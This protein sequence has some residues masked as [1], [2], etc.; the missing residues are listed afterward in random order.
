MESHV[1][2]FL[3]NATVPQL[4]EKLD[5]MG[6][7]S[8]GLKAA[9]KLR[10][11]EAMASLSAGE[12]NAYFPANQVTL[13][14]NSIIST[15]IEV[16]ADLDKQIEVLRMQLKKK[17]E[18]LQLQ[19]KLSELV[20]EENEKTCASG[21]NF[22]DIEESMN[23]F[24]GDNNYCISKWITNFEELCEMFNLDNRSKFICAKRLMTGT[25]KLFLKTK[26]IKS[27]I[28]L[29]CELL[30]E[31]S[32]RVTNADVHWE[33]KNRKKTKEE[34]CQ[35]YVLKMQETASLGEIDEADLIQYIVDGIADT[36]V[37]KIL[38]YNAN[39]IEDL[40]NS[41]TKYEKLKLN[42][43]ISEAVKFGNK[44]KFSGRPSV[45]CFNCNEVGHTANLCQK[46][47]RP[48]GSCFVCGE[49]GHRANQ[50]PKSRQNPVMVLQ[51]END[52]YLN[53]RDK[54]R[55]EKVLYNE[56]VFP[57]KYQ[58][59]N[60]EVSLLTLVDS[61]SASSFI[62]ECFVPPYLIKEN[63]CVG[64]DEVSFVGVNN[65]KL[66]IVGNICSKI[67]FNDNL[68][69]M[70]I[71]IVKDLTMKYPVIL[72]RNFMKVAGL[73][74]NILPKERKEI[75]CSYSQ[76][77]QEFDKQIL[78]ISIDKV[79]VSEHLDINDIV[80]YDVKKYV[81][82]LVQN[83]DKVTN[84]NNS[85]VSCEMKINLS[86]NIPFSCT[87]RR[88]S[89]SQ[90]IELKKI[91][92]DLLRKKIIRESNSPYASAIVL[93][94]KKNGE[95]RMCIDY[96]ELNK[97][98]LKD[99]Y[100]LPIIED[101]LDRLRDKKYFTILDMKSGF[102]HVK[103]AEESVKF[104]SFVTPLGQFEYLRMPFGLKNAPS[105]FQRYVHK[106]FKE[107][108]STDKLFSYLD[109]LLIA[110]S[111][112]DE[113]LSILREVINVAKANKLE[114][115]FDKCKFLYNEI[116]YLGYTINSLGIRPNLE[117]LRAVKNFPTP[118][119]IK[120]IHSFLGLA[121]YF[122]K[123]IKDFSIIAKPLYDK[124]K[125]DAL[126]HFGKEEINAF[127]MLKSKLLS[128]PILAIY[129][130]HSETELHCDA[131]ST[132]FGAILLQ[133]QN[134][135]RLH[136]IFY[137]SKRTSDIESR[138]HSFE[139]ETLSIIYAL[140][141]FRIYLLGIKF[142]IITDCQAF[143]LTLQKKVL[144]PRIS[145][146]V[147]ELQDFEYILEHRSGNKMQH[148]DALSR[149]SEILMIE[150][151]ELESALAAAQ[152]QDER[153]RSLVFELEQKDSSKFSLIN[154]LVYRKWKEEVRFY[155]PEQM[156][157][158]VIQIH[159]ESLCHLGIDKC[160]EHIKRYYW[161]PEM[162]GKIKN[163]ISNCLKCIYYSATSGKVEGE[164][165]C[166][167]KGDKPF[168]VL[169]IDHLG[170]LTSSYAKKKHVLVVIEAFTKFTKLYAVSSTKTS[171]VI[172]SLKSYFYN[173]SRPNKI[174][175][176]RGSCFTSE[177][178]AEFLKQNNVQHIMIATG[179]PQSNGQVERI[180]R[181]ITPMIAK[182]IDTE[183]TLTWYKNLD[184]I[185][186]AL[187][188]TFNKSIGTTS[189][190]LLFGV[191]QKGEV[192][193]LLMEHIEQNEVKTNLIDLEKVRAEASEIIQKN[194]KYNSEYYNKHHKT[195]H[196]Y[197]VGDLVVI[198]NIVSATGVNKKLIPKYKGPYQITKV[199]SNDRYA[200][201]DLDNMQITRLPYRGICSP[202]NMK[203]Y[204]TSN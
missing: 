26:V 46:P 129:N 137:F 120:E 42:R 151:G 193:D 44:E 51:D 180:N 20:A 148:V 168:Q 81:F 94:G 110:T 117:N 66:N 203:L 181:I 13:D 80:S 165:H 90:K 39:T 162:K 36:Y 143:S 98:T 47:K 202:A 104:T 38:L 154:G 4:K 55:N 69:N 115:R 65:S 185:E 1:K 107:L 75:T 23:T 70:N 93:V 138:Y 174:I 123:F 16:N 102:H 10:V 43:T 64:T 109:D 201:C 19:R 77:E 184:K 74:L 96:R 17:E 21:F 101:L 121:S 14:T 158:Q 189:S 172:L 57:I 164:L 177:D 32:K 86:K 31:F 33:L 169:H 186:F 97:C 163:Y 147:L 156:E 83:K 59:C 29:K 50:C 125:K 114:F 179:S 146:W 49:V 116:T 106:M 167:P 119:N 28:E 126:F 67:N 118:R 112:I 139:L 78:N 30:R 61:G 63:N 35:T 128:A 79:Q 152:F 160:F 192:N 178:F 166:I 140:R 141:R 88:L 76:E 149:C 68:I 84:S 2:C 52:V 183:N 8:T 3:E 92:D 103:M 27:W 53:G 142:K 37:N 173:Y 87:P 85:Y 191:N 45:K 200:I 204:Q 194:Q 159:H 135:N 132:G 187:N 95:T 176:D 197:R 133:R 41:L 15:D 153:I 22:R 182:G 82:D 18:I 145:R 161:F 91:L 7:D 111:T 60:Y 175:S 131:S 5:S 71:F 155:V 199:L 56:Y 54:S 73:K 130:P 134:D 198:K 170:P 127:E 105:V 113:H 34:T 196:K 99:N 25:A 9:L 171:E 11:E 150:N 157:K 48:K 122:R 40:K 24:S 195:P 12:I 72:G 190:L 100:P 62:Q 144:N 58:F 124:L 108:I 89:Y 6:L 136:P 188:N